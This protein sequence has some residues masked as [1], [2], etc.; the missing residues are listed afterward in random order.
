MHK[1]KTIPDE[2]FIKPCHQETNLEVLYE[3]NI[4]VDLYAVLN[5]TNKARNKLYTMKVN[6]LKYI[7]V[8]KNI[9]VVLSKAETTGDELMGYKLC[10]Y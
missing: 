8:E 5:K 6:E 2:D 9:R 1:I 7:R 10:N 3:V 4:G